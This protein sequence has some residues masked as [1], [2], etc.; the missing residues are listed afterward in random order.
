MTATLI[1]IAL[2]KKLNDEINNINMIE[3][4]QKIKFKKQVK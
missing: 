4:N 3:L 2:L 1:I